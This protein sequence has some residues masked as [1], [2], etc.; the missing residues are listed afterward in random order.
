[1]VNG[2]LYIGQSVDIERRWTQH[3]ET[4][5][6]G[7]NKSLVHNAISKYGLNNFYFE[8]IHECPRHEL[9]QW[10]RYYVLLWNTLSWGKNAG[11]YNVDL[12][13][14]TNTKYYPAPNEVPQE[15]YDVMY[16]LLYTD[17]TIPK[18]AKATGVSQPKVRSIDTGAQIQIPGYQYPLRASMERLQKQYEK[19][20]GPKVKFTEKQLYRMVQDPKYF[21]TTMRQK[22]ATLADVNY[23][24]SYYG[25]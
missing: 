14:S 16:Y 21:R 12:P 7:P 9:T 6:N 19:A 5:K 20:F 24:R 22:K 25:I 15:V 10:E 17:L 1:M 18:I 4:A 3:I 13:D 23:W 8:V 2:K 11:G